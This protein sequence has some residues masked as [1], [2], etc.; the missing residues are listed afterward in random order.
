ML[1]CA[2][3]HL[4]RKSFPLLQSSYQPCWCWYSSPPGEVMMLLLRSCVIKKDEERIRFFPYGCEVIQMLMDDRKQTKQ[5]GRWLGL[6]GQ[7]GCALAGPHPVAQICFFVFPSLS[8]P[9][10][11]LPHGCHS[12][13]CAVTPVILLSISPVTSSFLHLPVSRL[14]PAQEGLHVSP[15]HNGARI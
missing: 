3:L 9:P 7:A 14:T 13:A 8:R 12:S 10:E 11:F 2:P 6:W 1:P 4:W 15:D 5:P